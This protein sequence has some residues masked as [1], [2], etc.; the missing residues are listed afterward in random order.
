MVGQR[1]KEVAENINSYEGFQ[2]SPR[3][4]RSV[5]GSFHK[6][7]EEFR[8]KMRKEEIAGTS[9]EPPTPTE[10]ILLEIAEIL[11][12]KASEEGDGDSKT[13]RA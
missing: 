7:L 5:R 1:W 3:D 13:V 4:Q 12:N 6:L 10:E 9:P 11:S 8:A 2:I